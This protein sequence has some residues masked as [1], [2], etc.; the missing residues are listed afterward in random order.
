MHIFDVFSAGTKRKAETQIER[1]PGETLA[2]V[3]ARRD[4]AEVGKVMDRLLQK[5]EHL[6]KVSLNAAARD[7]ARAKVRAEKDSLNAEEKAVKEQKRLAEKQERDA[8]RSAERAEKDARIAGAEQIRLQ[9]KVR[10][11]FPESGDILFADCP[12]VITHTRGPKD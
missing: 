9:K 8:V 10:V 2:Q 1:K 11:A 4:T 3:K 6:S 5:V 12:P 7:T